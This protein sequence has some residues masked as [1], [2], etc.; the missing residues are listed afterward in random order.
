MEWNKK[1]KEARKAQGITQSQLADMLGVHRSTVANYEIKR[2]KPT[3][4][5]LAK[6]AEILKVDVNYLVEGSDVD[7][8]DDFLTRATDVFFDANLSNADK[9]AIFQDVMKL[10]MKGKEVNAATDSTSKRQGHDG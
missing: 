1:L 7:I 8:R 2:R 4:L 3:F 6:I 5:E 10:Y 9:D